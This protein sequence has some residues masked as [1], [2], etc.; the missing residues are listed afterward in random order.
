[1]IGATDDSHSP[2]ATSPPRIAAPKLPYKPR[3]PK[4][5]QPKIALVACGGIAKHHL[6]AYRKAGYAVVALCDTVLRKARERKR[7]F[8][9]QAAVY[10]DYHEVLDRDDIEVVDLA[11]H[12]PVRAAMIEA[13]LRAGK[14][15]LS[16]KP[17]VLDL[18]FGRRMAD[19]ADRQGARLAVNQN[20]RWAP[21]FSYI[22]QAV[23][24]GLI[25]EVSAAHLCVHWDH[26][27][28]RGTQFEKIKHLILYDFAIHWFDILTCIMGDRPA[29]SVYASIAKSPTQQVRP[30]LLAQVLIEYDA[31]QASLVFDGDTRFGP[32]D[33]TY[34]TGSLGTITSTGPDLRHQKVTLTT[35]EGRASP[36]L[37][38]AWFSDGFH[39]TMGELLLAVEEDRQPLNSGRD[40]LK[41]LALCFAAVASAERHRPVVPGSVRKMPK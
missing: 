33:S 27:L 25:G 5:Y 12:P 6:I 17:F 1:M 30:P 2:R 3:D 28:V 36:R 11:A 32:R 37:S 9:P 10:R 35:A 18:N 31:A 24:A 41:S 40:N 19:L 23:R 16:Q 38:G 4:H 14:H 39:G 34:V 7:E 13:A 29:R 26:N 21:H 8:F 20:G 22:R 15:V